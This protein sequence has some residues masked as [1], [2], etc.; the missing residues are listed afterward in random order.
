MNI[1]EE[2]LD[3]HAFSDHKDRLQFGITPTIL[4]GY[5]PRLSKY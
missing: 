5:N 3:E 4:F 1:Q 2:D